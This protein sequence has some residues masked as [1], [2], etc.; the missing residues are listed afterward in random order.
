MIEQNLKEISQTYGQ[1][2]WIVAGIFFFIGLVRLFFVLR[3]KS[4]RNWLWKAKADWLVICIKCL[5]I[6][7]LIAFLA[8]IPVWFVTVA[9]FRPVAP[10]GAHLVFVIVMFYIAIQELILSFTASNSLIKGFVKKMMFFL[11]SVFCSA[12]FLLAAFIVPGTYLYPPVNDCVILDLPVKGNWMAMHAGKEKWVNYHSNYPPQMYAMDIVKVNA[13]S[14]FFMNNGA[15]SSDFLSFGD[16]VFAPCNGII[17]Q[18]VNGFKT[19]EIYKGEDTINPA[20]NQI[21]IELAAK[22]YL[23]LAH[24][25]NGSLQVKAGDTVVA[26]QFLALAGNSGNTTFP[27]LHMHLQNKPILNDSTTVGLPYRFKQMNRKRFIFWC[28]KENAFLIRNDKFSH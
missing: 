25:L 18:T 19:Q 21:E 8:D 11:I 15:D 9:Q 12:S 17:Y 20:G 13:E 7:G 28:S 23:F 24:L 6:L 2:L 16:S 4:E 5:F 3:T 14:H 1:A 27:H 26:G 10:V 22:Q